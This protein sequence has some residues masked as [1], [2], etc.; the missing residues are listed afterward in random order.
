ME[1]LQQF[2]T[3]QRRVTPPSI[4]GLLRPGNIDLYSRPQVNNPDGSTS[5]VRSISFADKPNGHEILIPTVVGG[6]VVSNAD[7]INNYYRTG[8][9]L[10]M[11]ANAQYAT[12]YA[13]ELH[14]DY[15]KGRYKTR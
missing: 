5:T 12:R 14:N 8:Q 1:A 9:H 4:P 6:R 13:N 2:L 3:R 11:F 15:A 7:A 10:G